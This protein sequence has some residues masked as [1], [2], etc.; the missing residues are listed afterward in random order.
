MTS[1]ALAV[2]VHIPFCTSRCHYC[3][4]YFETG[5]SPRILDTVLEQSLEELELRYE[6]LG[7]PRVRTLYLGGG[8]PSVI[9][10][11]RLETYLGRILSILD[12]TEQRPLA[13]LEME[14]NPENTDDDL[15]S[16]LFRAAP[17]PSVQGIRY[18]L[19]VQSFSVDTLSLLGRR[20]SPEASRNALAVLNR[21]QSVQ[22]KRFS[23]N[24]DLIY[25][26]PGR[27]E[28]QSIRETRADLELL[29]ESGV[30]GISLYQLSVEPGT[31]LETR[32]RAGQLPAADGGIADAVWNTALEEL[33]ARGYR[34][35]EVSN[36]S[37]PGRESKHNFAYWRLRPYLG[38]GPGAVSTL[39]VP[40]E[41]G[42]TIRLTNPDLFA[43]GR[44]DRGLPGG[45]VI[46]ELGAKEL[47]VEL[48]ITGLRTIAGI[49]RSRIGRQFGVGGNEAA[50][51]LIENW[52]PYLKEHTNRIIL[53][54]PY[55]FTMDRFLPQVIESAE[56]YI[57][58]EDFTGF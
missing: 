16:A 27:D 31:P 14:G 7:R 34:A 17:A 9:P 42:R 46:E 19:G 1:D 30:D 58:E 26:T 11:G 35:Y 12:V 49:S 21:H 48:F 40:G 52:R 53:N 20:G 47:F 13:E 28:A 4:F 3:N 25:G 38:I 18:S 55:R 41:P 36:F 45:S 39:A 24:A 43:Y 2:Y 56:T 54:D 32:I 10:P 37:R 6:A 29:A 44:M 8:T 23:I 57:R 5:W 51:Y 33:Q 22:G 15:I 50:N